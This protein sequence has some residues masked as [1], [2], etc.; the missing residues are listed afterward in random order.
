MSTQTPQAQ[1]PHINGTND[2]MLPHQLQAALRRALLKSLCHKLQSVHQRHVA[3]FLDL[4]RSSCVDVVAEMV[5]DLVGLE[6]P[7]VYGVFDDCDCLAEDLFRL[8]EPRLAAGYGS[9]MTP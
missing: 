4:A 8:L 3:R 5:G 9:W 6:V 2:P 1:I 7:Q